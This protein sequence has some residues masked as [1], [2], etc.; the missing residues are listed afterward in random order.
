MGILAEAAVLGASAVFSGMGAGL[1]VLGFMGWFI[2]FVFLP[3]QS[4]YFK[5]TKRK[6]VKISPAAFKRSGA[7]IL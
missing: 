1:L 3:P 6:D 4:N 2:L 5:Q 7:F